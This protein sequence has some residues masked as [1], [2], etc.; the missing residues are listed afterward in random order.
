MSAL[1]GDFFSVNMQ[2]RTV[3]TI[4]I[5]NTNR[6]EVLFDE[7]CATVF[8]ITDFVFQRDAENIRKIWIK[9]LTESTP[10]FFQDQYSNASPEE[11]VMEAAAM[12][13]AKIDRNRLVERV[14]NLD[15]P[16]PERFSVVLP[17]TDFLTRE[18]VLETLVPFQ[19][20]RDMLLKREKNPDMPNVG[21]IA[22][23]AQRSMM[24]RSAMN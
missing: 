2:L 22:F 12:A 16:I 23:E 19:R 21:L 14:A 24:P 11:H 9:S 13:T 17:P 7:P 10:T 8:S 18:E 4:S 6:T 5:P 1:Q 20:I 3:E 15:T